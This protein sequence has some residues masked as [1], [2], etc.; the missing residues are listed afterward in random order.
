MTAVNVI[1][2][3][4]AVHVITDGLVKSDRGAINVQKVW[5]LPHISAAISISGGDRSLM[6]LQKLG[7]EAMLACSRPEYVFTQLVDLIKQCQQKY[8]GQVPE[9]KG[10]DAPDHFIVVAAAFIDKPCT[11]NGID[12][13]RGPLTGL[14][15]SHVTPAAMPYTLLLEP[16]RAGAVSLYPDVTPIPEQVGAAFRTPGATI[17]DVAAKIIEI[18]RERVTVDFPNTIGGFAQLTTITETA[19]LSR[20]VKRWPQHLRDAGGWTDDDELLH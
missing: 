18:Q 2:Q 8:V 6:L 10:D 11:I 14:V 15:A 13:A 19:T 3:A 9:P 20:V 4:D 12:L 7:Y 16:Q 17:E 1:Q 5:T